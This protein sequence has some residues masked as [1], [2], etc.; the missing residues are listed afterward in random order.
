VAIGDLPPDLPHDLPPDLPP[1]VPPPPPPPAPEEAAFGP[2]P[3]AAEPAPSGLNPAQTEILE[4]LGAR[5]G[6]RPSFDPR[7][8]D[9]FREE[10]EEELRPLAA[11]LPKGRPLVLSKHLLGNL[12]RCEGLFLAQQAEEFA[13]TVQNARGTVAHKAIELSVHWRGELVPAV[14]VD[15]AIARLIQGP[16]D[17]GDFLGSLSEGGRAEL[18]SA[19]V[20]H[21][22]MF[23]EC[24]PPLE[25]RWWPVTE[26]RLRVDLAEERISLRGKVDLT[27]GKASGTQAG[28]VLIDLKTGAFSP[29]HRED[30]RFYALLETIR[31]G[32]PP[33]LL[34]TYYLDGGRLHPEVVSQPLLEGAIRRVVEGVRAMVELVHL[35]R[36]PAYKAGAPCRWCPIRHECDAGQRWLHDQVDD[37][38]LDAA[39]DED[40]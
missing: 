21:T 10:L 14:L 18:R 22:T 23:L 2:A 3:A 25:Q 8:R 4:V 19:C 27:V 39:G 20:E 26:S 13:W 34:A 28:K 5:P 12:H 35:G 16:G 38:G 6:E 9:W 30:L 33:R 7:L 37:D 40:W 1:H 24:F 11:E 17:L 32:A 36:P 31:L 15:E 29:V